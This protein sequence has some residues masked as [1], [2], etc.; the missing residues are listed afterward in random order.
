MTTPRPRSTI[1]L[2]DQAIV[3][4]S[5]D[6]LQ[7]ILRDLV[8]GS[9][10]AFDDTCRELLVLNHKNNHKDSPSLNQEQHE[11]L[12]GQK[13]KER[14][15][16][17]AQLRWETCANCGDEYDITSNGESFCNYHTGKLAQRLNLPLTCLLLANEKLRRT[18]SLL[19]RR[20]L[21]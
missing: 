10:K 4:A 19:G 2:L 16:G 8:R 20:F 3:S 6:R 15:T 12:A 18:R 17:T 1:Q 14:D 11:Q 21:G 5:K 13:R 7:G 9:P